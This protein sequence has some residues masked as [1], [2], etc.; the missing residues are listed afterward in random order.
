MHFFKEYLIYIYYISLMLVRLNAHLGCW[1]SI[2]RVIEPV[3]VKAHYCTDLWPNNFSTPIKLLTLL[4]QPRA[5]LP[6]TFFS[7]SHPLLYCLPPSFAQWNAGR[8]NA[9]G[10]ISGVSVCLGVRAFLTPSGCALTRRVHHQPSA[11]GC[12]RAES[13]LWSVGS[14]EVILY[15]TVDLELGIGSAIVATCQIQSALT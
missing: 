2:I 14:N 12:S 5:T 11:D 4:R 1:E 8:R 6:S 7:L 3:K 13:C 10:R 15:R 9:G